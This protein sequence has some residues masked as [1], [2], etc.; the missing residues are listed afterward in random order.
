MV[1]MPG[2]NGIFGGVEGA[3]H[4]SARTIEPMRVGQLYEVNLWL[5]VES[6]KRHDPDW[7]KHL[8]IALLPQ[9]LSFFSGNKALII[10]FIGV[11][12]LIYDRWYPVKWR[13]RPLCTS[14][15]LMIGVFADPQWPKTR[16]YSD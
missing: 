15:Y 10:P 9:N 14:N 16:S 4:L 8:G 1:Y 3:S 11:D 6:A 5:Y 7:G 12:T 13:V 2:V